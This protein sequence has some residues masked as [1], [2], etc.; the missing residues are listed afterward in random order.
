MLQRGAQALRTRHFL[1]DSRPEKLVQF[2]QGLSDVT[3]RRKP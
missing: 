1:P 2:C 3:V